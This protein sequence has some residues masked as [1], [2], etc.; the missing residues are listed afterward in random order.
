MNV[1]HYS[2]SFFLG[3]TLIVV[4]VP[5]SAIVI[6]DFS[7]GTF[8]VNG[9][10]QLDQT[11]LDPAHVIGGTRRI[12]V[13]QNGIGS[14]LEVTDVGQLRLSSTGWGYFDITYGA[15]APLGGVDLTQGGHDRL[16]IR[17]GEVGPGFHPL[18]IYV[19]LPSNS[20][21]NGESMYVRDTWDG[22]LVEIPFSRF[23][24][25]FT[26][27]QSITLDGFRNPAG[28]GFAVDSIFTGG[29]SVA[30]DYN[31]D[32]V[33]DAADLTEWQLAAGN[34][35]TSGSF[36]ASFTADGDQDGDVDGGDLLVWQR[37]LGARYNPSGSAVPEPTAAI[38][39]ILMGLSLCPVMRRL[40]NAGR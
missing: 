27:V 40:P 6:D 39:M 32:G 38:L 35:A 1:L 2:R 21:S 7:V 17:F 4:A 23:P 26:A 22:V 33:V 13:G 11:G 8:V 20:S 25:P 15:I 36:G 10:G 18:G 5:A 9:P 14:T 3:T 37:N 28:A 16:L 29:P 34:G 12:D 24:V 30:G 19:S 31:R